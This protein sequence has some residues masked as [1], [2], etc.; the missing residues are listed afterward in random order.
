MVLVINNLPANAGDTRDVDLIPGVGN[1]NRLQY[2]CLESSMGRRAWWA[3]INGATESDTA[4]HIPYDPAQILLQQCTSFIHSKLALK[5]HKI[6]NNRRMDN[7]L[8][9]IHTVKNYLAGKKM[10]Y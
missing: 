10:D 6:S 5:T 3:T 4:E 7:E 1:G 9:Y 8:S 2:S